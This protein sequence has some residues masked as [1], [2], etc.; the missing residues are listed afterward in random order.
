VIELILIEHFDNIIKIQKNMS[1][2]K[3]P[4]ASALAILGLGG[5]AY[6]LYRAS[7][8]SPQRSTIHL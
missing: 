5:L 6:A 3:N 1:Q 4:Y 8:K 7:Q 2:S